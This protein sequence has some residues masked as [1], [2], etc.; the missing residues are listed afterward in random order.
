M[1]SSL[2]FRTAKIQRSRLLVFALFFVIFTVATAFY[3]LRRHKAHG[4]PIFPTQKSV[5]G[6][7]NG[8]RVAGYGKPEGVKIIGLVFF[9]RKNRVEIL[10]CFL[11]RNLVDNGGWLD[12]IHWVKNTD[13]RKDLAYLEEILASSSRYKMVE[14][15]G[16]GFVGYGLAWTQLEPGNLYVKIDDD[17]VWFAD[18]TIPRIVSMKLAHPDYLVVSANVVNSPLM[19]WVHYHMGAVHPYMPELTDY[20]PTI[21]NLGQPSRKPWTYWSYPTW[22]GPDDYFFGPFQAPPYDGHCWL[23]L[24]NDSDISRTPVADI[25]YNT[26]GT[27][28]KS[29]AIAAQEHYSFLEN[30]ADDRLNTYRMGSSLDRG[31]TDKTWLTIDQRLSINMITVWADDVLDNL[32]MDDVDEQW[33]TLIL[34]KKLKRQVAVNMDALAVH[35]TFGSQGTVETTDLLARY[36]DYAFENACA[37]WI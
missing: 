24:P 10:Q 31:G 1:A 32:P 37:R 8:P 30:L 27:G 2:R 19:G 6:F 16:V 29:W 9:G 23:R 25:E 26:W 12:E 36:R 15:E 17:V 21:F 11:Q 28:L 7:S 18:D 13:N 22:T 4:K 5:N 20:E 33:L 3:Q 35:F 14:V 34:P